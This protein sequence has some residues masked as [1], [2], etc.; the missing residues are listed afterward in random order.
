MINAP[1]ASSEHIV[2]ALR[3]GRSYAVWRYGQ[4]SGTTE[5]RVTNVT[6]D[7]SVL[8]VTCEGE[9]S[10]IEFIGQ[11]GA[12]RKAASDTLTATYTFGSEDTYIRTTI[13][14]PSTVMF[15]NPIVRRDPSAAETKA[16]VDEF[17]TW[18]WRGSLLLA[19]LVSGAVWLRRRGLSP[20]VRT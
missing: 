17:A 8:R 10:T 12:T 13:W 18:L 2:N 5:T 19:S 14:A 3:A 20:P 4:R 11:N 9:P 1:S 15:L 16:T 7:G 6:F